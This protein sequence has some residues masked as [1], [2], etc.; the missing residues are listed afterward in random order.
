M[1]A[2]ILFVLELELELA[3]GFVKACHPGG[4]SLHSMMPGASDTRRFMRGHDWS[5]KKEQKR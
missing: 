5:D 1:L 4:N 3:P 2:E